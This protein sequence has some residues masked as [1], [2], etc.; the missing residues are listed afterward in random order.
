V[1]GTLKAKIT[2]L[3]LA[4]ICL[5][6]TIPV[7]AR[8]DSIRRSMAEEH[9]MPR[10]L[11]LAAATSAA[12]G[13]FRGIAVDILW[14]QADSMINKKQFYQL[15]AYYELISVL[16]PNFPAVFQFNAW[17]LAFNISAEWGRPEEKWD[18]LKKGI[19]FAEKGFEF[20]PDSAALALDI[21]FLYSHKVDSEQ[22][23]ID[24]LREEKGLNHYE[25]AAKWA[26]RAAN[27][28]RQKGES[29]L[30]ERRFA[31]NA[32]LRYGK[33]VATLGNLAEA[34]RILD[35]S[36]EDAR[37][38]L[39]EYPEDQVVYNLVVEIRAEKSRLG[40]D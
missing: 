39:S 18:W 4:L 3:V 6:L 23:F 13:G 21:A 38:L 37:T 15:A 34:K 17:N 33:Y 8:I 14:I 31:C 28:A 35:R 20:N 32:L 22:Y 40:L 30:N 16:Q 36:E 1:S 25:E 26:L 7:Q 10:Q 19:E 11:P 9:E 2:A 24:K 12:M 29:G 27:L 5:G